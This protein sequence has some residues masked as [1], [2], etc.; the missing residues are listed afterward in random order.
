MEKLYCPFTK[1]DC[2]DNCVMNNNCFDSGDLENCMLRTSVE[3]I[4][5]FTNGIA[6]VNKKI[7]EQLKTIKDNTGSDQTY[8]YEINNR[9]DNIEN[10]LEK[11]IKK[12][13]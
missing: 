5:A 4:I 10:L 7:E 3:S 13:E 11:I 2:N 8:S 6:V 1:G 12:E 9:L